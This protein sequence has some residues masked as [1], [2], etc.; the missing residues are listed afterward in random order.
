MRYT[1]RPYQERALEQLRAKV[2]SRIKRLVLVAA[3]GSGKTVV[4]AAV[5]E[6]AIAKG[7]RCLFLAHRR[8]LIEQCSHK[9]DDI[10]VDHGIIQANHWRRRPA[11]PVQVAS[12]QTLIRRE[13]PP[14]DLVFIDECHRCLAASYVKIVGDYPDA[15]LIGASATPW[16]T[17]GRGLGRIYQDTV[18]TASVAELVAEGFLIEPRVFAPSLPDLAGVKTTAGDYQQDELARR[19]DKSELIGDVVDHWQRLANGRRTVVFAASVDHSRHIAERFVAAGVKAE[20]ADGAMPNAQRDAVLARFTSG[21]TTVVCNCDLISEGYDLPAISCVDLVRPTQSSVK[22][23]Q[24]VGRGMRPC[25]EKSDLVVLDH[26]GCTIR[27][28]FVT[29]NRDYSL[30]DRPKAKDTGPKPRVCRLCFCVIPAG[31]ALCPECQQPQP[32]LSASCGERQGPRE[33][34]GELE[35]LRP[36]DRPPCSKCGGVNTLVF[37]SDKLGAFTTAIRCRDCAHVEYRTDTAAA[38]RASM[39]V[40]RSEYER[41]D[42]IRKRKQYKAGWTAHRYRA[43]FGRWPR[44]VRPADDGQGPGEAA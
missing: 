5:I 24:M 8:E 14:A 1:L 33:R 12:I 27:H 35:E 20:H 19:M 7:S 40:K 9:L 38:A 32:R 39:D 4:M 41:L 36:G 28:G 37:R 26:A 15:V 3:T 29:D 25:P 42:E 30:E 23:L 43:I 16:R 10:G 13:R 34:D 22:Y 11:A 44:G 6:G 2:R 17:D 21:E 18:L 31:V